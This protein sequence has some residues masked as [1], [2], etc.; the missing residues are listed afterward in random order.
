MR[1]SILLAFALTGCGSDGMFA[2]PVD[3]LVVTGR[4]AI[5]LLCE[6]EADCIKAALN[7]PLPE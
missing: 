5:V 6:G 7:E 2:V 4:A 3:N 1:W